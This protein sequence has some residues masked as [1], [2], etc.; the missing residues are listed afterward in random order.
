MYC[1]IRVTAHSAADGARV[2]GS[3]SRSSCRI[4]VMLKLPDP[5]H[6]QVAGT[7]ATL[8]LPDPSHRPL[9]RHAIRANR[10]SDAKSAPD[11][12]HRARRIR[13]KSP[14]A[15]NSDRQND[16]HARPR[17]PSWPSGW[18]WALIRSP[19]RRRR[20]QRPRPAGHRAGSLPGV[21]PGSPGEEIQSTRRAAVKSC[22][23]GRMWVGWEGGAHLLGLQLD[24]FCRRSRRSSRES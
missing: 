1:R 2:A 8:K 11:P 20:G 10:T 23:V 15:R 3:E 9:G 21:R 22:A 6:A 7:R 13:A 19:S 12:A 18:R 14:P 16:S 5:S 17:A 4:R 24:C